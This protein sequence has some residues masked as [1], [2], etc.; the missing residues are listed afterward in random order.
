MSSPSRLNALCTSIGASI[1]ECAQAT[2]EGS[3]AADLLPVGVQHAAKLAAGC[4]YSVSCATR[5]GK[6][7]QGRVEKV[8]T[9]QKKKATTLGKIDYLYYR[10]RLFW[11]VWSS[12]GNTGCGRQ[13]EK[14]RHEV[15]ELV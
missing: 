9:I 2:A 5:A 4:V 1:G 13:C 8:K 10:S 14:P 6:K 7:R 15:M 3:V 11:A 12:T